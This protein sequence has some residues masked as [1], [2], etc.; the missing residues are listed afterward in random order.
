MPAWPSVDIFRLGMQAVCALLLSAPALLAQAQAGEFEIQAARVHLKDNVYRLDAEISYALSAETLKA[1]HNG[2]SLPLV[3]SLEVTRERW[4]MWDESVAKL[5]QR[6][7]L[8]Y[9]QLSNEYKLTYQNTGIQENF[10]TLGAALGTLGR[11]RDFPL[12][13]AHLVQS[14]QA[15]QVHLQS[16]LD[17]ESLPAP[18]RPVAYLSPEWRLASN[19]YTCPLK[20]S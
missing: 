10:N 8:Q 15:Y 17:I 2:I 5:K 18:L 14:G 12:L 7:Q 20:S 1:L 11:I 3:L 6:Y 9:Y 19:R 16:Y 13:D 4:Y